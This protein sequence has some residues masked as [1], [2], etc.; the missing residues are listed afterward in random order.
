[1]SKN[2]NKKKYKIKNITNDLVFLKKSDK[3]DNIFDLNPDISNDNYILNNNQNDN[4]N[5]ILKYEDTKSNSNDNNLNKKNN[6][7]KINLNSIKKT[8]SDEYIQNSNSKSS[9]SENKN[10]L[11]TDDN[12]SNMLL[13]ELLKKQIKNTS[14]DKKL[15]FNDIKR[16]S[17]FISSSIFDKKKCVIWNG[18][19][20]NEKNHSKGTYVNFYF[21][22]KKIALHRL[23]YINYVDEI[24]DNEYIKFICKNKGKCCNVNHMKKYIYTK[25]NDSEHKSNDNLQ[26][27]NSNNDAIHINLDKNKLIVEL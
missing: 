26:Q 17:K 6:L 18:Y 13:K 4:Q 2:N 19:I 8:R 15:N 10:S 3:S 11:E 16:I 1:M 14:S 22:K 12:K 7:T 21:N 27:S 5:N 25:N 24:S 20:T 23:L 9:N